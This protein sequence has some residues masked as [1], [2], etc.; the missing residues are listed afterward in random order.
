MTPPPEGEPG[1]TVE[2]PVDVGPAA[3]CDLRDAVVEV[4]DVATRPSR[5]GNVYVDLRNPHPVQYD[6]LFLGWD[7]H[8]A[9]TEP[10]KL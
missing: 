4:G 10:Q 5:H 9:T 7:H 3:V 6:L 1:S 8:K 2:H